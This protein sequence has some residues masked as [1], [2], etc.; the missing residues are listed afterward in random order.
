MNF[1]ASNDYSCI[2]CSALKRQTVSVTIHMEGVL[3]T[4][5]VWWHIDTLSG[6]PRDVSDIP[7]TASSEPPQSHECDSNNIM[8]DSPFSQP[9]FKYMTVHIPTLV[10]HMTCFLILVSLLF[11]PGLPQKTGFT[12]GGLNIQVNRTS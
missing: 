2:M 9:P 6:R 11:S 1:T 7:L 10:R 5:G 3:V 12:P 4:C 8:Q